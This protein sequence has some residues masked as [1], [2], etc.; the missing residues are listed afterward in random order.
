MF[1]LDQSATNC[2][3]GEEGQNVFLWFII[4]FHTELTGGNPLEERSLS[5]SLLEVEGD[6]VSPPGKLLY[7]KIPSY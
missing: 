7:K 6:N 3:E 4:F 2:D 1:D 5:L